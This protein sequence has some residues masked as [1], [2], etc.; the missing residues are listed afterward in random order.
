MLEYSGPQFTESNA[1]WGV[2]AAERKGQGDAV[3]RKWGA[4]SGWVVPA[5][6]TVHLFLPVT[7][8]VGA[9]RLLLGRRQAVVR[10]R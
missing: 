1:V 10:P 3:I 4:L 9:G 2:R 8:T 5:L 7:E 6:L